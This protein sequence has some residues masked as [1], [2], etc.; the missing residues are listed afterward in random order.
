[1]VS[2]VKIITLSAITG[3]VGR[4]LHGARFDRRTFGLY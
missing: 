1:M 3:T 4:Y 2:S